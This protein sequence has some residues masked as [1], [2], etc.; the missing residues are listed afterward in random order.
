MPPKRSAAKAPAAKPAK[1]SKAKAPIKADPIKLTM[2]QR[3]LAK[4]AKELNADLRRDWHDGYEDQSIMMA[5]IV[6]EVRTWL[7]ALFE[8]AIVEGTDL[9]AVQQCLILMEEHML[10]IMHNNCRSPF[11]QTLGDCPEHFDCS[12][13]DEDG[14]SRY[15]GS[16]DVVIPCFWR[17]LLLTAIIKGKQEVLDNFQSHRRFSNT[18]KEYKDTLHYQYRMPTTLTGLIHFTRDPQDPSKACVSD[19][20]FEDDWHTAA[21]KAANCKLHAF[22]L[23]CDGSQ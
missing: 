10:D 18:D 11:G 6:G 4:Q 13:S 5:D 17:D 14:N 3:S 21:M 8:V 2:Y 1:R 15:S 23:S 20:G 12:V 16:P 9:A 22:L 7:I 19:Q